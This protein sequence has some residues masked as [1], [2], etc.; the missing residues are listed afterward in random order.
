MRRSRSWVLFGAVLVDMLGF[1]IVIPVLPFYALEL[2]ASPLQVT[3]LIAS[4]SAMQLVATPI[5]GRVSDHHGRRPLLVAGLFVSSFSYFIFG[6]ATTLTTLL[7]S[8]IA[9]GAAGGTVSVAQAYMADST[10]D[11]DRAHG[12]GLIGAASGMGFMMGPAIGGFFSSFG[13]AAPGFVAAGLCALNGVAAFFLLPESRPPE[14][15]E[16][17]GLGEAATLRGWLA[18]MTARPMGRL[19]GVYFL[20]ISAFAAMTALLALYMEARFAVDARTMG[21][22]FTIAGGATVV[23]RGWLLGRLVRRYGEPAVVRLGVVALFLSLAVVPLIPGTWWMAMV[24]PVWAFGAGTLFPALAALVSRVSHA[25]SQGSVLGGQQ[26]VGG[27][28]RVAGPIWGGWLFQTLSTGAPFQVGALLVAGAGV[29]ALG[30]PAAVRRPT[31]QPA[32]EGELAAE[33]RVAE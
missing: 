6:L 4:Y 2:D 20:A 28:G 19:L 32:S 5:W 11:E 9:A 25:G 7:L 3:L 23:V 10:S 21:I 12:M 16:R 33:V 14:M 17:T 29:L 27:L 15:R 8:R 26:V 13:Y 18:A 24:V 31:E 30:L 22:I 1:G